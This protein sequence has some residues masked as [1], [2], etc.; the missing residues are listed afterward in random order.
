M[1]KPTDDTATKEDTSNSN[2]VAQLNKKFALYQQGFMN[3]EEINWQINLALGWTPES[4]HMEYDGAKLP[5]TMWRKGLAN[6]GNDTM[7]NYYG[8]LNAMHEAEKVLSPSQRVDYRLSLQFCLG[9]E[10]YW[11]TAA[12]RAEAFLRTLNLWKEDGATE[13]KVSAE[14]TPKSPTIICQRE[15]EKK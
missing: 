14:V 10:D 3:K 13:T 1:T 4:G 6:K 7:P 12:Q 15:G 2:E 11:A 8:D 9:K 5:W